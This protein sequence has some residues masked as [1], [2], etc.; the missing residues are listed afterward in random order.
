MGVEDRARLRK[1]KIPQLAKTWEN[2]QKSAPSLD[3]TDSRLHHHQTRQ[4]AGCIIRAAAHT[5]RLHTA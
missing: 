3:K 1:Y 4:T 2:L 5:Q